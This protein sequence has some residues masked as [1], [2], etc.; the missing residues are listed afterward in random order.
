MPRTAKTQPVAKNA[1]R[2]KKAQPPSIRGEKR[3]KRTN[4][5][6]P[7]GPAKRRRGA[8]DGPTDPA[9]IDRRKQFSG[10]DEPANVNRGKKNRV[11]GGGN[12]GRD[13]VGLPGRV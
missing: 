4:A 3:V 9:A 1:N 10:T 13:A 6:V 2:A 5:T 7:V 11:R 12:P 8:H